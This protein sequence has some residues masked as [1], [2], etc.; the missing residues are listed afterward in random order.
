[1]AE[2]ELFVIVSSAVP[3][4]FPPSSHVLPFFH[5]NVTPEVTLPPDDGLFVEVLLDDGLLVVVLLDDGLLAVV[6]LDDGLLIV[7]LL[8]DGLLV[9][10][11]PDDGAFVDELTEDVPPV[12]ELLSDELSVLSAEPLSSGDEL[13]KELL[14]DDKSPEFSVSSP[15]EL[16]D[17][18][19]PISPPTAME[20]SEEDSTCP[21]S[22]TTLL[23]EQPV[24]IIIIAR[25][26]AEALKN[27][28]FIPFSFMYR[29]AASCRLLPLAAAHRV[30]LPYP[31]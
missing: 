16:S 7:V 15:D 21:T 28:F 23:H 12:D 5:V 11:L 26:A 9:V 10:V 13:S 4:L 29:P 3:H 31:I 19:S 24:Q 27:S 14:S 22:E 6:L 2:P 1:M 20:S 30:P 8:D 17:G 18:I 25:T